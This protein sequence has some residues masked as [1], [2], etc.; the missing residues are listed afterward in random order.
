MRHASAITAIAFGRDGR[1]IITGTR[2]GRLHI[3][4]AEGARVS[5]LPSQGAAVTGLDV[6]AAVSL[7]EQDGCR[8]ERRGTR[9]QEPGVGVVAWLRCEAAILQELLDD[10]LHDLLP[11]V[12]VDFQAHFG[13]DRNNSQNHFIANVL[14]KGPIPETMQL[15]RCGK[16]LPGWPK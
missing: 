10:P 13:L 7:I 11:A 15:G 12:A 9:E 8:A 6:A 4:D 2:D 5:V 3:W 14:T 16:R 1:S